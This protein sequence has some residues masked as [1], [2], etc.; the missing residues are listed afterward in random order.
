ML[1]LSL[2]GLLPEWLRLR[3]TVATTAPSGMGE[4]DPEEVVLAGSDG[5]TTVAQ[6]RY[7][8]AGAGFGKSPS[9]HAL[10]FLYEGITC[11]V[12]LFYKKRVLI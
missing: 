11:V 8:S 5:S 10:N 4:R 9:K 6:Q 12:V 1:R 3:S 7:Y 2:A